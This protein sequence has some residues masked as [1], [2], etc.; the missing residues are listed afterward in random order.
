MDDLGLR[1]LMSSLRDDHP[2]ET[3]PAHHSHRSK[4]LEVLAAL[5]RLSA[6][7][8]P[9]ETT[10]GAACGLVA[11][12]L[13]VDAALVF[14]PAATAGRMTVRSAAGSLADALGEEAS[15]GAGTQAGLA[16]EQPG[17]TA[18]ADVR[19]SWPDDA[20]LARHELAA[21]ALVALPGPAGP[22]GLLGVYETGRRAFDPDELAFLQAA[23]AFLAAALERHQSEQERRRLL[24][25]VEVADR[26]ASI[27]RLA[28]G[29]AH[30][31]N[32]PL[33]YVNANLAFIVEEAATL[34]GRLE[35]APSSDTE[36]AE[37]VRQLIDAATDTRD[38]VET[39]RGLVRDLQ[40][41]SRGDESALRSLDLTQVLESSLNVARS[42]IGQRARLERALTAAL[43]PVRANEL[44][45]GQVF[46][47]LLVH[48]AQAIPEGHVEENLIRVT[49]RVVPGDR[50][51]VEV[52]DTGPGIT[53]DRLDRI[54]DPSSAAGAPGAGL[55]LSS[56]RSV[57]EALG[58]R[59]EVESRPGQGITRRVLLPVAA[60]EAIEPS[61][62]GPAP[63]ARRGRILVVDD[64]PMVGAVMERSLSDE[65]EVVLVDG[66]RA[67]MARLARG[68]TFDVIFSDLLMPEMSG[69]E[70]FGEIERLDPA[71]AARMVFLSGGAFTPASREFLSRPGV[72]CIEKPFDLATIREAI[73]RHLT[74]EAAPA[75]KHQGASGRDLL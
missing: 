59:L 9:V 4:F 42:E 43:P 41:L 20:F 53:P 64:E 47:G 45:L 28:G 65:F 55:G 25:Q 29:V 39:M 18:T 38:G 72:E 36:L 40:T 22:L 8:G 66:G 49:T 61:V 51:A 52:S 1:R 74:P 57:V 27:G 35:A 50:V 2:V 30:E 23:G 58:G 15:S 32:N 46:L 75:G 14:E 12:S 6:G 31:L 21:A 24:S 54:L 62:A 16:L 70:L 33:S 69:M 11:E 68:E 19:S 13:A 63:A 10:L 67:A 26:L 60:A 34:A 5:G 44:R 7:G 56:C 37:S 73:A 17:V 48:A 3:G 71:L